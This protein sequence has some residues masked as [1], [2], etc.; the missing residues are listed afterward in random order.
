MLSNKYE[1]SIVRSGYR[2]AFDLVLTYSTKEVLKQVRVI[3][4]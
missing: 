1:R 4:V 2:T 3:L